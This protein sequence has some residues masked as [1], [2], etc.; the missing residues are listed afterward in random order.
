LAPKWRSRGDRCIVNEIIYLD[1]TEIV[2]IVV[3]R[4]L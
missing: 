3:H 4:P 1:M 2:V